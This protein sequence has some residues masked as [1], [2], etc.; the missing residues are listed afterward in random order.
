MCT[1]HIYCVRVLAQIKFAQKDDGDTHIHTHKHP[2]TRNIS[3]GFWKV[4]VSRWMVVDRPGICYSAFTTLQPRNTHTHRQA[5]AFV[6]HVARW[7]R[8]NVTAGRYDNISYYKKKIGVG[9]N[10]SV[11]RHAYA[12]VC[13]HARTHG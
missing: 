13:A 1:A 8:V 11:L 4:F 3:C 12:F 2:D 5:Q 10:Y 6:A 9:V 7:K